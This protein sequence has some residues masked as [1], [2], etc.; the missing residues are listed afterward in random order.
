MGTQLYLIP[1][2]TCCEGITQYMAQTTQTCNDMLSS[3]ALGPGNDENHDVQIKFSQKFVAI[4]CY[5]HRVG[6]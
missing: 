6:L 5:E 1:S 3:E 2:S 4:C